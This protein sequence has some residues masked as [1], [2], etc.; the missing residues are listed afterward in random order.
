[1]ELKYSGSHLKTKRL[2]HRANQLFVSP[3]YKNEI[4]NYLVKQGK[5]DYYESFKTI[6]EYNKEISVKT[7]FSFLS[8]NRMKAS[9]NV[10]YVNTMKMN[11]A[12]RDLLALLTEKTFM[13]MDCDSEISKKLDLK[14][15]VNRDILFKEIG[16]I[17]KSYI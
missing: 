11:G 10:V 15:K 17:S 13:A 3:F 8:K 14:S 1:M 5:G 6:L 4:R 2:V 9:S 12:H 7:F 16:K